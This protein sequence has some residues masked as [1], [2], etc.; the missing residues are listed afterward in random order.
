MYNNLNRYLKFIHKKGVRMTLK[1]SVI[2][3]TAKTSKE[4]SKKIIML[5]MEF[6][7]TDGKKLIFV[8]KDIETIFSATNKGTHYQDNILIDF[9][10]TTFIDVEKYEL[11]D[12]LENLEKFSET[13]NCICLGTVKNVRIPTFSLQ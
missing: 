2:K 12:F 10:L 4:E 3:K 6:L 13:K 9:F 11:P 7:T 1:K 5:F 8:G